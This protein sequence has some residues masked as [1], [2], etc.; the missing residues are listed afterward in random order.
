MSGAARL[1]TLVLL[2]ALTLLTS[3]HTLSAPRETTLFTFPADTTAGCYPNGTLLRDA[4]GVL[5]GAT[6]ACPI[7]QINTVF[8]LTP[9]ACGTNRMEFYGAAWLYGRGRWCL[10]ERKSCK[11]APTAR[12]TA[13][14]RTTVS[15]SEVLFG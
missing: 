6:G 7:S 8:K 2:A 11:K 4:N 9:P 13:Q 12:Y 10:S 1:T 15:F 3:P 14:R 5:Y